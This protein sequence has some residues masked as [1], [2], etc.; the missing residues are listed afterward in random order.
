MRKILTALT[1]LSASL[2]QAGQLSP[3]QI[4]EQLY[5]THCA[6]CHDQ[7]IDKAPVVDD[8]KR[9][10][11][12]QILLTLEIG[13]MQPQASNMSK[14]EKALVAG[15]L[16][17]SGKQ[18]TRWLDD[19]MCS[20]KPQPTSNTSEVFVDG[21]GIDKNNTRLIDN[22]TSGISKANVGQLKLKWAFGFDRVNDMRSQP[23]YTKDALYVGSRSG[24][25]LA[26][27]P[28]TG[29]IKWKT[30]I[31]GPVRS[32]LT[33]GEVSLNGK[34]QRT[35]IFSDE[36]ANVYTL[37]AS[38]GEVLWKKDV[39]VFTTSIV[40]GATSYHEG[41]LFVPISSYE[42]AAAGMP[43]FPCCR[44]H[45]AVV[46]LDANTGE[47]RWVW[48]ATEQASIQSKTKAGTAMWGP[49]GSPV[50]TTPLIDKKRGVLYIGTGENTSLPA[51]N[52]SDSIFAL[53]LKT[54]SVAWTFQ[55]TANDV[56]NA[57]C[58]NGGEACPENEGPDFDFGAS[59]ILSQDSKGKAVLLAGQKSGEVFSFDP[60]NKGKL[61]WRKR[62]SLGTTNGGIHWG[63]SVYDNQVFVPVSDPEREI[64]GYTP[65]P[66]LYA[67]DIDSGKTNWK[68][69][70]S[71]GCEFDL[72]FAPKIGLEQLRSGKK[73]SL[74]DRYAC[75]WYYGLSAAVTATPGL[76]FAAGLDGKLRAYDMADGKIL[77]QTK[78]AIPFKTVNGLNAHGGA[79]DSAGPIMGDGKLFVNSG[80]S[81]FGQLPGNVLLAFEIEK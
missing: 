16:A 57:A 62:I 45:G 38:N 53:D 68:Q 25:V 5:K 52:S 36:M 49:S 76:V 30:K 29:C 50:W 17:G 59:M 23:V 33:L 56:W 69:A 6:A 78:T 74:A 15:Y 58:L 37:L 77:W 71:R 4:G 79:I 41:Q 10:S 35:L 34:K 64:E 47:K 8:L 21:W 26:L 39:A 65:R 9:L 22:A 19:A 1:L 80:Y 42:I 60:D 27:N 44:S 7:G 2:S 75:S 18:D 48:H 46:S 67:M 20:D 14:D 13:R 73:R 24:H 43:G 32:S 55:A 51:T 40:T 72:A 12:H 81:M 11:A 61:N 54:G 28:D 3:A 31:M 63:M 70:V 66:G